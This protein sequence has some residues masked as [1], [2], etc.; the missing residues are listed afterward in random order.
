MSVINK[1]NCGCSVLSS[2]TH[3]YN[4]NNNNSC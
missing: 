3:L 1:T 2:Y 4:A